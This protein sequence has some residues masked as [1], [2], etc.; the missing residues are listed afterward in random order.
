M[1]DTR[2]TYWLHGR[3]VDDEVR[4]HGP[5]LH[6]LVRGVRAAMPRSRIRREQSESAANFAHHISGK[7]SAARRDEMVLDVGQVALRFAG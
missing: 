7:S 5:E 2:D 3:I 4:K 1:Q 6:R